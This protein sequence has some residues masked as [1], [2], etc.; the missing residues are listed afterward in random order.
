MSTAKN[1]KQAKNHFDK[2]L[3]DMRAKL[4]NGVKCIFEVNQ[5]LGGKFGQF[6]SGEIE[7]IRKKT[8]QGCNNA[9]QETL[10]NIWDFYDIDGNEE[11]SRD[12]VKVM[13]A[14]W[15]ESSYKEMPKFQD[16]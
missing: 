15:H 5:R 12:E 6:A 10:P 8:R 11:L 9:I 7:E 14:H 1:N 13:L 4:E 16:F 3:I 2:V